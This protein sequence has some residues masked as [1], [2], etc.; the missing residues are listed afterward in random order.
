MI[1][2]TEFR[3]LY[4]LRPHSSP[5]RYESKPGAAD[6]SQQDGQ[7]R[8]PKIGPKSRSLAEKL[9]VKERADVEAPGGSGPGRSLRL[10]P[11]MSRSGRRVG[12]ACSTQ[13][14]GG[15]PA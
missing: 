14:A 6:L 8:A 2:R 10:A 9:C 13:E 3:A 7:Q 12:E 11:P 5:T 1:L 15:L 4:L